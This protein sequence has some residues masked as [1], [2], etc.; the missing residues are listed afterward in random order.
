MSL[1]A[2]SQDNID[3]LHRLNEFVKK[4]AA[5][6]QEYAKSLS[7]LVESFKADKKKKKPDYT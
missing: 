5:I 2:F 3:N 4:R 1:E 6:E 7:K